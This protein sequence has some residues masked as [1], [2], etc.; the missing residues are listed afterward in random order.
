M[1]DMVIGFIAGVVSSLVAMCLFARVYDL[2]YR[3]GS[4]DNE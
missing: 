4:N 1:T 3:D 2:G